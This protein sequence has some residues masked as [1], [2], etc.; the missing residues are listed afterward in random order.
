MQILYA[1]PFLLLAA[2]SFFV[3]VSIPRL[4][5]HALVVPVGFLTFGV[6][7]L[8][9]FAVF[10]LGVERLGYKGPANWFYLA[11]YSVGG[12]CIAVICTSIY[13]GIV[14]VSPLWIIRINLLIGSICSAV[15][16]GLVINIAAVSYT[17][18]TRPLW[19]LGVIAFAT[20]YATASIVSNAA[21]HRPQ[22]LP[23]RLQRIVQP[24]TINS[25]D[26]SI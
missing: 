12:L 25:S 22:P 18:S 9:T 5:S 1:A 13:K 19:T 26:S 21:L 20:L 7:A 24:S 10:A 23:Q 14:A 11:P 2:I 8:I 17:P 4:R 6:G 16:L 3:C 15:V